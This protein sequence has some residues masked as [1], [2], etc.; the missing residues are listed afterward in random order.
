VV[1]GGVI[2]A[3]IDRAM[4]LSIEQERQQLEAEEQRLA[5]RRKKLNER[6]RSERLKLVEQSG[7]LKADGA[8]FEAV[9]KALKTLGIE[10]AEKRLTA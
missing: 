3:R 1:D 7:L 5:D 10:E 4:A 6:E 9:M 2:N 8:R